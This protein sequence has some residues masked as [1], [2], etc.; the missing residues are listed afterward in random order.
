MSKF[1]QKKY[2]SKYTGAEIDAA[3]AKAGT[4]PSVTEADAGKAL[5][6]DEEGKIV[7]GKVDANCVYISCIMGEENITINE[8]YANILSLIQSGKTIKLYPVW[9]PGVFGNPI[10]FTLSGFST[11]DNRID[12][13]G[14]MHEVDPDNNQFI[15]RVIYLTLASDDTT[16]ISFNVVTMNATIS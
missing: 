12:F 10:D 1:W 15:I 11:Q 8:T 16:T 13:T 14:E 4:V 2:T 6:V 7:T 5:V 3:V 9:L